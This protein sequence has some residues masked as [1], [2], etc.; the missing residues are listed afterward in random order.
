[1]AGF[2]DILIHAYDR[3]DMGEIWNIIE[4]HV[5]QLLSGLADI[6]SELER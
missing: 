3:A 6:R 2:R 4:Q 1:M 5:P